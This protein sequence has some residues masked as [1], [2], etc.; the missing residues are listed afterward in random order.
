[1]V[2]FQPFL[3]L[4]RCVS[5]ILKHQA[6]S[7]I[8]YSTYLRVHTTG[9]TRHHTTHTQ[10]VLF[11]ISSSTRSEFNCVFE[12]AALSPTTR[13]LSISMTNILFALLIAA[14]VATGATAAFIPSGSTNTACCND[15][16]KSFL[17]QATRRETMQTIASTLFI[18]SVAQAVDAESLSMENG[19]LESRVLENVLSPPPYQMEGSDIYYPEYFN[20]LWNVL[21]TTTEVKAPC[22]IQLFGG[23]NTYARAQKEVNTSL[24]YKA[25]FVPYPQGIIA[26]REYNVIS[27]AEAALGEKSVLEVPQSTPNKV[28]VVLAPN[29]ANQILKADLITI[30]RRTENINSNEFHCSEVVRQVIGPAK[31]SNGGVPG[32]AA[33]STLFKEI[34]TASLYTAIRNEKGDVTEIKCVQRS[35]TFL[36]PSQQD[37]MAYKMWELSRGRPIDVRFYTVSYTRRT[38]K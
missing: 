4:K 7:H 33:K 15:K 16:S 27:I 2:R 12:F 1:M 30:A 3:S 28:T 9:T 10:Q 31:P 8:T 35:A 18:P 17:L 6:F 24:R 36:L 13:N 29:G 38:E 14:A 22:G 20:G 34:E 5:S 25:R 23:N 26:D 21:S 37:P 32:G 11:V 19:L